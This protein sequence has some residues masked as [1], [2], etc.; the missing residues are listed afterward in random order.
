MGMFDY[1]K[2]EMELP[3]TIRFAEYQTKD[4]D[5]TMSYYTIR[6]D[7]TIDGLE[8]W[9][10]EIDFYNS[11]VSAGAFGHSFVSDG[12]EYKGVEFRA[13]VHNGIVIK[14][15]LLEESREPALSMDDY[16][17][18][19]EEVPEPQAEIN[20]EPF[21]VGQGAW[22]QYGGGD[23]GRAVQ[24]VYLNSKQIVLEDASERVYKEHYPC[25]LLFHTQKDAS[26]EKFARTETW[27]LRNEWCERLLDSR[28]PID[29]SNL[30]E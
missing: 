13:T 24:V 23:E 5:C 18:C 10:G 3:G 6:T 22:L 1:I 25:H 28:S 26:A 21:S 29:K 17:R 12:N 14:I 20:E 30:N 15:D 27:R 9:T 8:D 7:G 11:N 2:C 4:L 16:R 19:H